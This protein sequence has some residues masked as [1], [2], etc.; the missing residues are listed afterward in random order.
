MMQIV[1]LYGD[2]HLTQRQIHR[3][4][5]KAADIS[6]YRRCNLRRREEQTHLAF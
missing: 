2:V 3:R 6:V 5:F 4:F 1:Q